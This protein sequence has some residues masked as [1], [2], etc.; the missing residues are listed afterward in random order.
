MF[1]GWYS[2]SNILILSGTISPGI[3]HRNIP[4]TELHPVLDFGAV[5]DDAHNAE[6]GALLVSEESGV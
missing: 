1:L 3:E 6:L 5:D 4:Q 2:C